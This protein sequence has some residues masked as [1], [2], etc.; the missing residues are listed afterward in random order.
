MMIVM[1]RKLSNKS[2]KNLEKLGLK[3]MKANVNVRKM[4]K[5]PLW[6]SNLVKID[7]KILC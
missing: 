6:V 2:Q 7:M 3:S 1:S 4:R 5:S